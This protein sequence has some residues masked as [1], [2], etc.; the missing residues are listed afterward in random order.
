MFNTLGNNCIVDIKDYKENIPIYITNEYFKIDFKY[1][2]NE[3]IRWQKYVKI[4]Q[5]LLKNIWK[6]LLPNHKNL[7][8]VKKSISIFLHAVLCLNMWLIYI[9]I[10]SIIKL[11][12]KIEFNNLENIIFYSIKFEYIC[13]KKP[14]A[15]K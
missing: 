3:T 2:I 10:I 11:K 6:Y 8:F 5:H 1:N 15:K 7:E 13:K 14:K 9:E 12:Q 4:F